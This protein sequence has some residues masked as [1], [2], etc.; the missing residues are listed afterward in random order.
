MWLYSRFPRVT[1]HIISEHVFRRVSVWQSTPAERCWVL[2]FPLN[3]CI[4]LYCFNCNC[5]LHFRWR[6]IYLF[7]FSHWI[8]QASSMPPPIVFA[9]AII[10][11]PFAYHLYQCKCNLLCF[12]SWSSDSVC[13]RSLAILILKCTPI[14]RQWRYSCL[15]G[16]F[17]VRF[18]FRHLCVSWVLKLRFSSMVLKNWVNILLVLKSR[19]QATFWL[20]QGSWHLFCVVFFIH[21]FVLCFV[22]WC[23]PL[24]AHPW[25]YERN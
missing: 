9:Y 22:F 15:V 18:R 2:I 20:L 25:N 3:A 14:I 21:W 17:F 5:F 7:S 11:F 6:E 13:F 16:W 12:F 10:I 23:G 8:W 1:A 4:I 19:L 24:E